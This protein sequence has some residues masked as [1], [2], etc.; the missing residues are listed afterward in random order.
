M[1]SK[2]DVNRSKDLV[3]AAA[4][5]DT[6]KLEEA[7]RTGKPM[8]ISMTSLGLQTSGI[9]MEG[10]M[11]RDQRKAWKKI[12]GKTIPLKVKHKVMRDGNEVIE[13]VTVQVEVE[14]NSFNFGV[15]NAAYDFGKLG[16]IS[17]KKNAKPMANLIGKDSDK[18][19]G[20]QVG[21]WLLD[22]QRRLKQAGSSPQAEE[23]QK[24]IQIVTALAKDVYEMW[25][26][27][28][29]QKPGSAPYKMPAQVALL[30][31]KIGQTPC[32]NCKSGKDRT[33]M[34]D[35]ECKLLA[36]EIAVN[37]EVPPR[38]PVNTETDKSNRFDLAM[39]SGSF[40]IQQLNSGH[41]GYKLDG[42][43]SLD[44]SLGSDEE[45]LRFRGT[46]KQTDKYSAG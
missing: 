41:M 21:A 39:N 2:A 5:M 7:I 12:N 38:N 35:V 42:V 29:H 43:K 45:N 22:A 34:M 6:Q 15:N 44:K 3:K 46:S 13:E 37:G 36:T 17:D 32:F 1:R 40:E 24:E 26:K 27:K 30:A 19:S 10:D 8:K 16:W 18:G 33:S 23:I 31:Q 28:E 4:V 20:G 9:G 25:S 14:V 11:I